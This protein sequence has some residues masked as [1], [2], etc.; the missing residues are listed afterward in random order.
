MTAAVVALLGLVAA[1]VLY[2]RVAGRRRQ[3]APPGSLIDV[4]NHRLHVR[5][6]GEGTPF[7]LLEAGVAASSL[8]WSRVQPD[9][10]RFT[11]VCAYDRA[12]LAWSDPASSPRTFTL[13][14]DELAR[15]IA[16]VAPRERCILVGHSFGSFVVRAY[17]NRHPERVVGL[18]LVDPPTEWLPM[19]PQRRR[20][21]RRGQRLSRVGAVLAELGIVRA[22]LMMLTGG[23]PGA[24]RRFVKVF[25]PGAAGTLQRLVGE[26]KK[27]PGDVHPMV[28]EHWCQPKCFHSMADHLMVLERD[29]AVIA[30]AQP[31]PTVPTVVISGGHQTADEIEVHR[32]LAASSFAGRHIVASRSTHWVQF[33]EPE[34]IVE[35]VKD[36][37]ER[38]AVVESADG[39]GR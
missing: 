26:V 30:A 12:G 25:G 17:A 1:G 23:A 29:G 38:G 11:R 33:D 10:A 39:V 28:R 24:P 13:I 37:A 16:N 20:L 35:A 8:G 22:C 27:L 14:V 3:F 34:L 6:A 19:T 9:V 4:G 5:C 7:V 2:Q 21:I 32:A 36:L 31:P 15:V 18:V